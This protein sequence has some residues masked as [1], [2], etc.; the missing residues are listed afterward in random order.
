MADVTDITFSNTDWVNINA[1][2]GALT[3]KNNGG[4]PISV[5]IKNTN[6]LPVD[7]ELAAAHIN[8]LEIGGLISELFVADTNFV[9]AKAITGSGSVQVRKYGVLDPAEDI[10]YLANLLNQLSH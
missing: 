8:P 5:I 4:T 10:S 6:V 7:S 1:F 3:I 2:T 9:F